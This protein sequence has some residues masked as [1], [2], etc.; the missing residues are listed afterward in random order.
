[1][2]KFWNQESI[3]S[4]LTA[5]ITELSL[6]KCHSLELDMIIGKVLSPHL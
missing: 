6:T 4:K 2:E 3:A 1:M 5:Q